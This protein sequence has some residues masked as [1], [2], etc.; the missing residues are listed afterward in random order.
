MRTADLEFWVNQIIDQTLTRQ[1]NEDSRVELKRTWSRNYYRNARQ[2]AGQANAAQE[3][4]ILWI[5]GIDED[6][7][8]IVGA[9][10]TELSDWKNQVYKW[11]KGEV[12]DL[13]D[14][15]N[16]RREDLNVT[17]VALLFSTGRIPYLI[18]HRIK[19]NGEDKPHLDRLEVPWRVGNETISA[20]RHH[21]L[22]LLVPLQKIPKVDVTFAILKQEN[23]TRQWTLDIA[24]YW[25]LRTPN[26]VIPKHECSVSIASPVN[27]AFKFHTL[28]FKTSLSSNYMH[29][30]SIVLQ[31]SDMIYFR[32]IFKTE[33]PLHIVADDNLQVRLFTKP[34]LFDNPVILTL[35]MPYDVKKRQFAARS[36]FLRRPFL[37]QIN[38]TYTVI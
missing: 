34:S 24:T 22:R 7:F 38:G 3:E 13:I 33:Q 11:F 18:Y 17:V 28:S 26:L 14:N 25:H 6:N 19:K 2:L 8:E 16:V 23:D 20:Q 29:S 27:H 5:I 35:D 9:E 12:P 15:I 4:P 30:P 37:Y 36:S 31:H 1:P 32:I 10:H 21:L